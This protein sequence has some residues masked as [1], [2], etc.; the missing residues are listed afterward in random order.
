MRI[1][2]LGAMALS[3]FA[4]PAVAKSKNVV[5]VTSAA[6]KDKPAVT[7][8]RAQAHI[9]LRSDMA[10][11]LQLMKVPS[12]EDQAAYEQM[13]ADAF[14]EAREKY[15]RKLASYERAKKLADNA[16]KS[17]SGPGMTLPEKPIEPT[18]ANF[19]FTA[20]GLLSGVSIGPM[21]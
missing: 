8:D 17:G 4:A 6:V 14:A 21:N 7:L 1:M 11:A 13:R 16:K 15:T 12:A 10:M 19:E 5:F 20:F 2:A 3:L 9:L 18:E